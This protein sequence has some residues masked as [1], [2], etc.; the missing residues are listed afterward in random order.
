MNNEKILEIEE[1]FEMLKGFVRKVGDGE[2]ADKKEEVAENKEDAAEEGE[3]KEGEELDKAEEAAGAD[4]TPA[5]TE[6]KPKFFSKVQGS[7]RNFGNTLRKLGK[8]KQA[9]K[10]EETAPAEAKEQAEAAPA[11]EVEKKAE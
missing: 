4:E 10:V 11:E 3:K 7:I 9:D 6:A 8:K 5:K 1:N 2:E